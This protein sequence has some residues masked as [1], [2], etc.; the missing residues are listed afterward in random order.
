MASLPATP[1]QR[2][3]ALIQLIRER[4]YEER[5]VVL[6]SGERSSYYIDGKQVTLAASGA[7]LVG[8]CLLDLVADLQLAAIGGLTLGADPIAGAVAAVSVSAGHPVDGFIVRKEAKGHGTGRQIEGPSIAGK[9]VGVVDDTITK[10]GALLTAIAAVEAAG[11]EVAVVLALVDR[12]QGGSAL[13][14]DRG[15]LF[16]A[17][18]TIDQVQAVPA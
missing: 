4:C 10:G 3:R 8:W 12:N 15:Y 5:D 17:V 1:D 18:C 13:L 16:R 9:R 6:S 2:R 7:A 11:A 14:R